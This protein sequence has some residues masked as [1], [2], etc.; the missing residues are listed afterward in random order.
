MAKYTFVYEDDFSE[1][2]NTAVVS[3]VETDC[4]QTLTE[5]IFWFLQHAGYSYI[6]KIKIGSCE[7]KLK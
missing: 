4:L 3:T 6:E 5:K 2:E 7:F 1:T